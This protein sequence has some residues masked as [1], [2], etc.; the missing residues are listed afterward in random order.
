MGKDLTRDDWITLKRAAELYWER[1]GSWLYDTFDEL[2]TLYWQGRLKPFPLLWGL[3]GHGAALGLCS[4]DAITLHPSLVQPVTRNPWGLGHSLGAT[5]ARDV[6][7]HEQMHLW[8]AQN[9]LRDGGETSHN[10]PSWCAEVER[11]APLVLG[12]TV[13]ARQVTPRRVEGQ[14][15]RAARP[16]HLEQ[17]QLACFP[18]GLR[19]RGFYGHDID[20]D[21]I[22]RLKA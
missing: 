2:N 19:P 22:A 1:W 14:L 9:G 10:S 4:R 13:R 5:L 3:T 20:G 15:K 16:G 18:H 6:L 11:L 7:L 17:A 8:I 12:M 21:I